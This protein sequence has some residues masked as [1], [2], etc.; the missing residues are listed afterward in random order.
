MHHLVDLGLILPIAVRV[1][2]IA[3]RPS[4]DYVI[5]TLLHQ[6]VHVSTHR[7]G[8]LHRATKA[9]RFVP[10]VMMVLGLIVVHVCTEPH[11]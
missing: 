5:H 4:L 7:L 10:D 9:F 1:A 11:E 6:A 2:A 3:S 8:L